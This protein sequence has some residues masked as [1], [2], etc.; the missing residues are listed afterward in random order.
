M[1]WFDPEDIEDDDDPIEGDPDEC[2]DP[3]D[4]MY[5]LDKDY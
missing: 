2:E 3:A 5:W 1:S 4:D